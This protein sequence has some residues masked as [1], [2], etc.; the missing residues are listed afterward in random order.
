MPGFRVMLCDVVVVL[1]DRERKKEKEK[2]KTDKVSP[3]RG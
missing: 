3:S 2:K 1:C